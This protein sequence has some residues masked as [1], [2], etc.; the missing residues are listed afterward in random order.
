VKSHDA[1]WAA[2]FARLRWP[3]SYSRGAF[4]VYGRSPLLVVP[5]VAVSHSSFVAST[6]DAERAASRRG[7]TGDVLIVGAHPLPAVRSW[8]RSDP[9]AGLLG[10]RDGDGWRWEA[11]LWLRC[12]R[13]ERLA[14]YHE[15]G[16][17]AARPCG[18]D[19]GPWHCRDAN[20]SVLGR[21][22]ADACWASRRRKGGVA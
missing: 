10:E 16:S 20:V 9:P 1:I 2:F 17:W 15:M 21:A 12:D 5:T 19:D 18:H 11:G 6:A 3:A 4:V 8:L 13:C 7:W 22:W 14:V